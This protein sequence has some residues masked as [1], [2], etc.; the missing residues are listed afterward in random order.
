MLYLLGLRLFST[1]SF[2]LINFGQFYSNLST[3]NKFCI[4]APEN[5]STHRCGLRKSV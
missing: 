2:S 5:I 3:F 1:A 4:F